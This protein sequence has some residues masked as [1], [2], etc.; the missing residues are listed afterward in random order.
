MSQQFSALGGALQCARYAF[1]PNKL[2]YCGGNKNRQ[3]FEYTSEIYSDPG[4]KDILEE[5]ETLKPYLELI[6]RENKIKDIFDSK[7]VEAYWIG[8]ELLKKVKPKSLYSHMIDIQELKKKVRSDVLEKVVGVLPQG[9]MPHHSFHVINI[10]KRTG[11]YPVE[12][13]I[14][15]MDKCRISWGKVKS[16]KS[17]K[18]QVAINPLLFKQDNIVLGKNEIKEYIWRIGDKGFIKNIKR[19]DWVSI[20]WDFVCDK[21]SEQ[22]VKNLKY[23]TLLSIN[24]ANTKINAK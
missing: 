14:E 2:R 22:Q 9:A 7:V 24:L 3:L 17:Y 6:A 20:H 13:T 21:I 18:L 16:V 15:T 19:G 11:H 5:F 4:L 1:M 23:Y 10:P 12:H 8:N